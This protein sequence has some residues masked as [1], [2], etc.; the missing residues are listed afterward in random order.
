MPIVVNR[1]ARAR[2]LKKLLSPY[3]VKPSGIRYFLKRNLTPQALQKK[4]DRMKKAGAPMKNIVAKLTWHEKKFNA[5]LERFRKMGGLTERQFALKNMLLSEG[6]SEKN[7]C[8]NC[9][10][11]RQAL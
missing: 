7:S 4:L 8:K 3:K 1:K 9:R 10:L 6:I 2:K 11:K 5:Y